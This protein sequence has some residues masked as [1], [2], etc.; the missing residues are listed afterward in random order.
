MCIRDSYYLAEQSA[1]TQSPEPGQLEAIYHQNPARFDLPEQ[2]MVLHIFKAFES[3]DID[4]VKSS[5]LALRQRIQ[6]GE[7][8]QRLASQLS[9]SDSRSRGGS[10]GLISKGQLS[11]D[12]DEVV[13]DLPLR[14]VSGVITTGDGA[15][16][17]FV[18]EILPARQLGFEDVR[19][20]LQ[21]EW[22]EQTGT[23]TLQSLAANIQSPQSLSLPNRAQLPRMLQSNNNALKLFQHL[24]LIHI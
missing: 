3:D 10:L 19:P 15:H 17:F 11:Q 14:T 12:F 22:L 5:L 20:V 16:L 18:N 4:T 6:A 2:R 24:S 13:F 23:Q 9:D 1:D 8:F 7:S 21:R